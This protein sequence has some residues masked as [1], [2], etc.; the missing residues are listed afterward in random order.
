MN[1][2]DLGIEPSIIKSL[3]WWNSNV[4]TPSGIIPGNL[5]FRFN[6]FTDSGIDPMFSSLLILFD[7]IDPTTNGVLIS[8]I[9]KYPIPF[10]NTPG[11]K[12]SLNPFN[13]ITPTW[14][15]LYRYQSITIGNNN[16]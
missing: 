8:H 12:L 14:S 5:S 10:G 13:N 9:S 15:H 2:I 1:D 6:C 4:S 16:I 11:S 3:S 7:G